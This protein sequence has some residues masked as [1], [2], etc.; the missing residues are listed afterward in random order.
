MRNARRGFS[1][2]VVIMV[3]ALLAMVGVIVLSVVDT[4]FQI[5]GM[6]RT[7]HEAR[8]GAEAAAMEVLNDEDLGPMLPGYS[9]SALKST[10]LNSNNSAFGGHVTYEATVSL[11]RDTPIHESSLTVTRAFL[12]EVRLEAEVGNGNATDEVNAE[13]Y[14]VFTVPAG[15]VL[16]DSHAR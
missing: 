3:L 6:E 5:L 10:Y 11:V 1:L 9:T 14:K 7:S 13:I 4:E 2:L 15:T 16:P 8:F 12:Y